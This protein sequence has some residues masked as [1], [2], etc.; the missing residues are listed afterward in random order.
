MTDELRSMYTEYVAEKAAARVRARARYRHLIERDIEEDVRPLR[1][2]LARALAVSGLSVREQQD[3][4]GT[5]DWRAFKKVVAP[6]VEV[7]KVDPVPGVE[8]KNEP[9]EV[10]PWS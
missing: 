4:I 5:R 10:D 1:D 7:E 9:E 3:I 6:P 2:E 8:S